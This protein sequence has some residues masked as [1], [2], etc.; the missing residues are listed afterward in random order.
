MLKKT[1]KFKDYNDVEKTKDFYF[2]FSKAELMVM[3]ANANSLQ[4]RMR[5]IVDAQDGAA[6]LSEFRDLV[7]IAVGT[8]SDDGELFIKDDNAK[9]QLLFSPAF[10]VIV[11]ELATNADGAAEFMRA[12]VPEELQ[13]EMIAELEA[14]AKA[15]GHNP[16]PFI[17]PKDTRPAWDREDRQPTEDEL[18]SMSK[19][20][21]QKAFRTRMGPKPIQ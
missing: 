11:M 12:L 9:N 6:I 19:E 20:E 13:K 16:D 7:K 10:D 4:T 21:M 2:H 8:R 3:A 5:R 18:R 15:K 1:I 17:E 14:A